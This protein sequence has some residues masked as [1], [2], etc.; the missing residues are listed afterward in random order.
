[1]PELPEIETI[2]K[3]L[4]NL[5]KNKTIE[6]VDL[7]WSKSL[8][9]LSPKQLK[10]RIIN[11]K[12]KNTSRRGKY[13]IIKLANNQNLL[14]H[15]KM[16][17]QLIY[18]KQNLKAGGGHPISHNLNSLPSKHTRIVFTFKNKSKLFFNDTRKFGFLKLLTDKQLNQE[19]KKIGP[20]P[21]ASDFSY[22]KFSEIFSNKK[23]P[24]KPA[25]MDA[26]LIAGIGNIYAN[27]ICFCA[28]V[29]PQI[30]LNKLQEHELK[31][32]YECIKKVLSLAVKHKG[33]SSRDYVDAFGRKGN[34][35]NY[36]KVYARENKKCPRCNANIKR[37]IQQQRSTFYCPNCQSKR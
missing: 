7:L 10:Q 21:L 15:L 14:F 29:N 33:T 36:L 30:T 1:M 17:G 26:N 25:L 24:V 18:Q 13:L 16:T 4:T 2:K 37:I 8:K 12:V 27:E 34:M 3:D 31:S 20:E 19:L 5:L 9:N 23:K 11:Q 22:L 35:N 32:I 6:Q 28:Q